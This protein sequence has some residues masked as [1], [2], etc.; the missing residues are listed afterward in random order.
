MNVVLTM[1]AFIFPLITFPYV[2]RVL[3]PDGTG[4][5]S[6]ALS[7]VT[8]FNL[9]AQLGI[10]TYGV[11]TCAK[12]RDDRAEL[13]KVTQELLIINL[14]MGAISYALFFAL[15][16]V[17][18]VMQHEKTLYIIMS[19]FILFNA[20]GME[21][22]YRGLEQYTY[23]TIRSILFKLVGL[24][25]MFFLI[26][27]K[28]DYVIYGILTIFA[29]AASNV[30][31]FFHAHKY[32]GM[33]PVGHYEFRRHF[34][35]IGVF[36]AM[37]CATTIYTNLD[38][39]MLGHMKEDLDVGYYNASVRIKSILVSLV[40][41]LGTVLLP[42]SS[43]FVEHGLMEDF[44]RITKKAL[45]FVLIVATPLTVY[46]MFF[47]KEGIFLL[48]GSQY[49]G[50]V[51]PMQIIM[52]TLIFIGFSNIL[53]IQVLVPLGQE[54]V[55][56]YSEV[57]GAVTDLIIN[58]LLIPQYGAAGAAVG[59]LVAEMVVLTWQYIVIRGEVKGTFQKTHYAKLAI[60][61]AISSIA[62][63]WVKRLH[64]TGMSSTL[65][66]FLQLGISSVIF[67]LIYGGILYA[68]KES[69][70]REIAHILVSVLK[71]KRS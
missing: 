54:K 40:T 5:V 62:V 33:R 58:L 38:F 45:N 28:Q 36:F 42:R 66:S 52:P 39:V 30:F 70:V 51:L 10:P 18:P 9:F 59:T 63:L 50:A 57:A 11:R 27:A 16:L 2:S 55:V 41:S 32:I 43:Y 22:L 14:V 44:W 8:Y 4:K 37:S 13:T 29:G 1:S 23:I 17:N 26:R 7:W 53:G 61:V 3:G 68:T 24:I 35:A 48:A 47:A 64:F 46:F 34:K 21:W 12:I 20:I 69:L 31:N 71:R 67:F 15:M 56:L 49:Q 65:E 6:L 60:S 19:S 25:A